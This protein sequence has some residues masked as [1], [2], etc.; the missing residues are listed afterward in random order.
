[1]AGGRKAS[2][3]NLQPKEINRVHWK[4]LLLLCSMTLFMAATAYGQDDYAAPTGTVAGASDNRAFRNTI[5]SVQLS[6]ENAE[7][8]MPVIP[9]NGT[10][11]LRLRFDDL[12]GGI[13]IYTFTYVHC[14]FDWNR[15]KSF[16]FFCTSTLPV[17][18]N[19]YL[20]IG[21]IRKSFNRCI[22][23]TVNANCN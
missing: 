19:N 9:L 1:M 18:Y 10:M 22:Y 13:K 8:G 16:H 4:T 17:G 15:N 3:G 14:D 23:I 11:R 2:F 12:E 21:N 5:R 20:G 7:M 6:P